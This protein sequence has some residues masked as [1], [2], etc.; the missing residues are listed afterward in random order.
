MKKVGKYLLILFAFAGILLAVVLWVVY[1]GGSKKTVEDVIFDV[2]GLEAEEVE[3]RATKEQG[4]NVFVFYQEKDTGD[5]HFLWLEQT[6][7]GRYSLV[8]SSQRDT[9]VDTYQWG[10]GEK[11]VFAIYG[12]NEA[13][14]ASYYMFRYQN[15]D[16]SIDITEPYFLD[17]FTLANQGDTSLL[18]DGCILYDAQGNQLKV[19]N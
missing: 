2:S 6:S 14:G 10:S 11:V 18:V 13:L 4:K 7:I 16:Y 17:V 9:P 12:D 5:I 19:V 1:M 15:K 3:I 8:G